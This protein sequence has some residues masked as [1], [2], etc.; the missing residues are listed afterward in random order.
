MTASI[1]SKR[2]WSNWLELALWGAGLVLGL[3]FLWVKLRAWGPIDQ[4]EHTDFDVYYLAAMAARFNPG[5]LYGNPEDLMQKLGLALHP[6]SPYFYP[7]PFALLVEPLAWFP[8]EVAGRIFFWINAASGLATGALIVLWHRGSRAGWLGLL[9]WLLLPSVWDTLYHGNLS[10]I[11]ALLIFLAMIGMLSEK[12]WAQLLGGLLLGLTAAI[13]I[14]PALLFVAAL[15]RRKWPF[16]AGGIT[17]G[18][19]YLGAGLLAL[20]PTVWAPFLAGMSGHAAELETQANSFIWN[21]SLWAFWR[22]VA[23]SGPI[24]LS[25][26]G[27]SLGDRV[28]APLL[29]AFVAQ[30]LAVGS[31]ALI[32]A[33]LLRSVWQLR[34]AAP[35]NLELGWALVLLSMLVISPITWHHYLALLAPVFP[36]ALVLRPR[37]GLL[38]RLALPVA[39]IIFIGQ[40]GAMLLLERFPILALSAI[41]P[42][43]LLL[44]WVVFWRNVTIDPPVLHRGA[45]HRDSHDETFA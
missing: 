31:A 18:L 5:L 35:A 36:L 38:L 11:F 37:L 20:P 26:Q 40:R 34:A 4:P 17:T 43:A 15:W 16:A 6:A 23:Y 39:Y 1:K 32:L 33:L 13:K 19:L 12:W 29:P 28:A 27:Q 22:K 44:W 7:P 14:Y 41:L 30:A 2:S 9:L 45:A 21:E 42:F 3:Y 10:L 24:S 25:L 8:P